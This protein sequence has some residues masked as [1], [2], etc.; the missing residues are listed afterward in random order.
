M[1]K[2]FRKGVAKVNIIDIKARYIIP[3]SKKAQ[4]TSIGRKVICTTFVVEALTINTPVLNLNNCNATV[5]M[6]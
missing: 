4:H 6:K 3:A 5:V 1:M 2:R